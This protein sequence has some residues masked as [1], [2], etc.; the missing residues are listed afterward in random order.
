[1]LKS[2]LVT[3]SALSLSA[4]VFAQAPNDVEFITL[5]IEGQVYDIGSSSGSAGLLPE[6]AD[7]VTAHVA[8]ELATNVSLTPWINPSFSQYA[9]AVLAVRVAFFDGNEQV[10]ELGH[11][12]I[13]EA[14]SDATVQSNYKVFH[15]NN[16]LMFLEHI[17]K[18]DGATFQSYVNVRGLRDGSL[19]ELVNDYLRV[20]EDPFGEY[21]YTSQI[22]LRQNSSSQTFYYLDVSSLRYVEAVLDADGDGVTDA[23]DQ[24]PATVESD[25]VWFDGVNSG[26]ANHVD[27]NGC[28]ISDHYASCDAEAQSSGLL[29]YSGPTQC[30]MMMGYQLYRDGLIDYTELRMLRNAL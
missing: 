12:E 1:M 18:V 6:H 20:K 25:T 27:A 28:A 22:T 29:A 24:C 3:L 9:D 13:F 23:D 19:F 15:S 2:I 16:E 7:V 4:N 30:E 10:V 17:Y 21:E 11:P 5:H 8:V 14:A 26:V